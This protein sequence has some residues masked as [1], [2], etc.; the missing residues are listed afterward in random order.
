MQFKIELLPI[1]M[2]QSKFHDLRNQSLKIGDLYLSQMGY[3]SLILLG[4]ATQ[5][6]LGQIRSTQLKL[7]HSKE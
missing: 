1:K 4:K 2:V 6:L 5:G 7:E 3:I